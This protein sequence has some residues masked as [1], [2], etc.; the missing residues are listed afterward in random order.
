[1]EFVFSGV[2]AAEDKQN[3]PIDHVTRG[4]DGENQK[5]IPPIGVADGAHDAV[6]V[7]P[8]GYGQGNRGRDQNDEDVNHVLP[9]AAFLLSAIMGGVHLILGHA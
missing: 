3:H 9:G 6:E 4:D 1:M 5:D 7:I 8:Q 2:E